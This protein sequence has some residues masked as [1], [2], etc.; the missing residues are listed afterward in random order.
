MN[1]KIFILGLIALFVLTLLPS[2]AGA[3]TTINGLQ[4]GT[5]IKGSNAS[6]YYFG[7]DGKRYVFPNEKTYKTWFITFNVVVNIGD[8]VL[9]E[10]P[11]GGN[12]TYKPGVRLVKITTDPKVYYVDANGTLRHV[13]SEAVAKAL[14][15]INW[16]KL[17]DDIPDAFF[18]NYKVG[19]PIEEP[20]VNSV[21]VTYSINQD[22]QIS[23]EPDPITN[24]IGKINL[25]GSASGNTASLN[26][27]VSNVTVDQ[28]FKVVVAQTPDPVYPG[29]DY[30]YLSDPNTRSDNWTGL[31]TGT[32]YFRVCQY[33][34]G[35]CGVYSNNLIL[36][37]SNGSEPTN[38]SITLK[39]TASGN[40]VNLS[41]T[42]NFT[43]S[44]GYKIVK[45]TEANPVYPGND[46]H[47]LSSS[48][49]RSDKWEGLSAGTYHFRVC[50]YLGGK[51]GVYSNDVSISITSSVPE[52]NG[53]TGT[54]TLK[55]TNSGD[56]VNLTWTISNLDP[57]LGFKIVKSELANPVYPGN[58]YHYL[59][60]SSAR[61]DS[62]T[63]LSA[64]TYHFRVCKYLGGACGVYS[65]DVSVTISSSSA[66]ENGTITLSGYSQNGKAYLSWTMASI[67]IDKG[68]SC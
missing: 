61:T 54:I 68:F 14:Y 18:V 33:L 25:S 15:G 34:G 8:E 19:A 45:S 22:K 3:C 53:E 23:N 6:V 37:I 7:A 43:S 51:C 20:E 46:Y 55:A 52:T 67:L 11:I 4:T 13:A 1:K 5:L 40:T 47:Y 42:P 2:N 50:E 12:V 39:A 29:N 48:G 16:S 21:P 32:Y 41:W 36:K 58:E 9:G 64:G 30:H 66:S 59:S 35:K 62:W 28:G 10:V 60:D 38:K 49:A 31:S 27:E 65:N 57:D 24:E 63:G 56:T 26:W 44:M 17:V